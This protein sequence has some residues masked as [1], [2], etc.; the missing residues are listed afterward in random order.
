MIICYQGSPGSGKSYDAV[1]RIIENLRKGRIVYTNIEGIDDD[2][3]R[4]VIKNLARLDDYTITTNLIY[5][6]KHEAQEFWKYVKNN[7]FILIDEIHKLFNARDWQNPKNRQFCDWA[8]THRHIG[9][10]V[11][12]ITQDI[13]KVDSQVRSLVEFTYHYR[14]N[15]MFGDLF[16]MSS[17]F[18]VYAYM[19]GEAKGKPIGKKIQKYNSAVF[20]AYK[21]YDSKTVK[22]QGFQSHVN[23]LKHPVFYAL[24][25]LLIFFVYMFSKSSFAEGEFI[26]GQGKKFQ[27]PKVSPVVSGGSVKVIALSEKPLPLSIPAIKSEPLKPLTLA[28]SSGPVLKNMKVVA[29]FPVVE[30]SLSYLIKSISFSD[31]VIVGLERLG[32]FD[33]NDLKRRFNRQFSFSDGKVCDSSLCY[34]VGDSISL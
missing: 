20:K 23:V 8:S 29:P 16:G 22:E 18:T 25:V 15:N 10:D 6:Q 3:H 21:S 24:P 34:D 30:Q 14:K 33:L 11:V 28:V 13:N 12:M 1:N 32:T 17:T 19:D 2:I 7:S 27:K 9:C 4:E 31:S 5:L 26:P